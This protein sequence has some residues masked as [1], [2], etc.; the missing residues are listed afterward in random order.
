M[1]TKTILSVWAMMAVLPLSAET[2]PAVADSSRVYDLDE[3]VVV[4]QAKEFYRL[5]QQPLS[6]TVLSG[7]N[8]FSLSLRDIR[9]VSDFVPSFVMPNYGSRFT[10]SIYVRGIG[11]R[12][13]SPSMGVNS[14][15][16]K[17][18]GP[19]PPYLFC[20]SRYRYGVVILKPAE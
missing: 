8:L 16:W 10:S 14:G 17:V 7:D 6:S 4:S 11:S 12:V 5:R 20:T 9:E 15:V 19:Q 2:A 13:N 3:V 18:M 1:K